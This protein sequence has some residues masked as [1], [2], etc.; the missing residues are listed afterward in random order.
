MNRIHDAVT[1]STVLALAALLGALAAAAM[2]ARRPSP[3]RV[4][5][6]LAAGLAVTAATGLFAS[7]G[8]SGTV[9]RTRR[10]L[11][12]FYVV[13]NAEPET[14]ATVTPAEVVPAYLLCDAVFWCAAA[15]LA[16]ALSAPPRG[17][18]GA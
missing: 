15:A 3:G 16:G 13:S 1:A 4:A 2:V 17:K 12:H 5:G 7:V 11:P 14:G 10:G 9:L 6:A 18:H 8:W